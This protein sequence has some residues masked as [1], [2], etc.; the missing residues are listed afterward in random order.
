MSK[1]ACVCF[2]TAKIYFGGI[3]DNFTQYSVQS[4]VGWHLG[5]AFL[6]VIFPMKSGG[7]RWGAP[8][9]FEC[10]PDINTIASSVRLNAEKKATLKVLGYWDAK[11]KKKF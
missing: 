6:V 5:G 7:A 8:P 11:V 1:N 10:P 3:L 4:V 9:K 2:K